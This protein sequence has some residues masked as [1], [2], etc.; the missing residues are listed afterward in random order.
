MTIQQIKYFCDH[1][2]TAA[3]I[4]VPPISLFVYPPCALD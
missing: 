4:V 1:P 3:N 2:E